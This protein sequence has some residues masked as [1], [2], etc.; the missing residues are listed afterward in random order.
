MAAIISNNRFSALAVDVPSSSARF[1]APK[2]ESTPKKVPPPASP[3]PVT[4]STKKSKVNSTPSK[5]KMNG[6]A[7]EPSNAQSQQ[8]RDTTESKT[9]VEALVGTVKD[10]SIGNA[11]ETVQS[12]LRERTTLKKTPKGSENANGKYE[13]GKSQKAVKQQVDWEIPR[14]TLHSSIGK[15]SL[16][17]SVFAVV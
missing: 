7:K 6:N 11:K 4:T 15:S 3:A 8:K 2:P 16:F 12:A 13:V 10:Q 9:T 14:K 1:P 17:L 5:P